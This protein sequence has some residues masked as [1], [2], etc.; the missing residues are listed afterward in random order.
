MKISRL[1]EKNCGLLVIDLQEKFAPRIQNWDYVVAGCIRLIK[2]FRLINA[3]IV[4]TEQYPKGLGATIPSVKVALE[5]T[6]V[7]YTEKTEFSSC[8]ADNL[9]KDVL[10]HNRS[11]WL[12]CGIE[13]HVCIQ[14]TVFDLLEMNQEVFLAEDAISAQRMED[15]EVALRRMASLGVAISTSESLIFETLKDAKHPLFKQASTI[16]KDR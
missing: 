4:I 6:G 5:G 3:P 15:R 9:K 11:Q 10:K 14:Q 7:S 13:A 16:V 1:Q 8:G 2:F 12:V